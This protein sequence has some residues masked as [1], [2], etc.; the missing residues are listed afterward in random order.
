MAIARKHLDEL[1]KIVTAQ[2]NIEKQEAKEIVADVVAKYEEY[3]R[4][5]LQRKQI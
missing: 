3:T 4:K 1:Q 5:I 2:E